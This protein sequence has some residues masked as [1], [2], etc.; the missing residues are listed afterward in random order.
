MPCLTTC[1]CG[2]SVRAG[3]RAIAILSLVY[4]V[5][6]LL[7]VGTYNI[8]MDRQRMYGRQMGGWP[9]NTNPSFHGVVDTRVINVGS[10]PQTHDT[11]VL[12]YKEDIDLD[13]Y[14]DDDLE[15][16]LDDDLEE[17]L[18][19]APEKHLEDDEVSDEDDLKK[20]EK[21]RRLELMMSCYSVAV[22][23]NIVVSL[24]LLIGVKLE[25]RWLLMPWVAWNTL[26]LIISQMAIFVVPGKSPIIPDI[27][28]TGLS[29][30]CIMCVYS[31]FQVLSESPAMRT[32]LPPV[33]PVTPSY[34]LT[35]ELPLD[36]PPSYEPPDNPPSYD[37]PPPYPGLPEAK[38]EVITIEEEK[39]EDTAGE[40]AEPGNTNYKHIP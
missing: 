27:F 21:K 9:T 17:D 5:L 6:G 35:V 22:S 23:V 2:F 12:T 29:I 34:P 32:A 10:L 36:Q 24:S 19:D 13:D 40:G 8:G 33:P 14:F 15:E 30:Y 4:S 18:E 3:T 1:C 39:H 31:Y 7:V 20:Y 11:P 38:E 26:S 16:D 28:S 37:P 25:K